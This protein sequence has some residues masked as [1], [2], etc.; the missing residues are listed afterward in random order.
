MQRAPLLF[1]KKS[2]ERIG[3]PASIGLR[4]CPGILL[5]TRHDSRYGID[6]VPAAAL[7]SIEGFLSFL[8][9]LCDIDD[10]PH[11]YYLPNCSLRLSYAQKL[12]YIL[13]VW[14]SESRLTLKQTTRNRTASMVTKPAIIGFLSSFFGLA[15]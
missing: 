11:R 15:I 3:T 4:L 7:G 2:T 12:K 10:F 1:Q 5:S 6:P 8:R 14:E 13:Y 9:L